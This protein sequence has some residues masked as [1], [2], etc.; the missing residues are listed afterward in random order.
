MVGERRIPSESRWPL[1]IKMGCTGVK[2]MTL[3]KS[4]ANHW[5]ILVC[6]KRM[7]QFLSCY[8]TPDIIKCHFFWW[9]SLRPHVMHFRHYQCACA[10]RA[11]T[12]DIEVSTCPSPQCIRRLKC[13]N[14]IIQVIPN[15]PNIMQEWRHPLKVFDIGHHEDIRHYESLSLNLGWCRTF[16]AALVAEGSCIYRG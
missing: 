16:Y 12:V 3:P 6:C 15:Q 10:C 8:I 1:Q 9:Y 7:S 2:L 5:S 13:S 11:V 4:T 14:H